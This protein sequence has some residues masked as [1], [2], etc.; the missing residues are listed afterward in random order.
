MSL[1]DARQTSAWT[2]ILIDRGASFGSKRYGGY[3]PALYLDNMAALAYASK[4]PA[5]S[6]VMQWN[7]KTWQHM[8]PPR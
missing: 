1:L 8:I 5:T 4:Y 3:A 7:G 2:T 6:S